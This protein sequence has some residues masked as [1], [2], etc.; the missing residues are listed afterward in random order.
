MRLLT[1]P[2]LIV[3]II[4]IGQKLDEWRLLDIFIIDKEPKPPSHLSPQ[5]PKKYN[6]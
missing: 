6:L 1:C 5:Q 4:T 3:K 2:P